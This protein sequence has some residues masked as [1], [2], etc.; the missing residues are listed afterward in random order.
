MD[1]IRFAAGAIDTYL[2]EGEPPKARVVEAILAAQSPD[3][4]AQPFYRAIEAIGARAADEAFIALRLVLAGL[5]NDDSNVARLRSLVKTVRGKG[6]DAEGAR[7]AYAAE[8]TRSPAA[9]SN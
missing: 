5:E 8:L 4:K 3:P 6:P 7:A 1:Q 9:G 2:L